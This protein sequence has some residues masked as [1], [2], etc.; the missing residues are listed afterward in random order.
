MAGFWGG[1]G[2]K[3]IFR[4][5]AAHTS[6]ANKTTGVSIG[7]PVIADAAFDLTT[8]SALDHIVESTDITAD[9]DGVTSFKWTHSNNDQA[10]RDFLDI[11]APWK[12]EAGGGT[13]T[14]KTGEE[15]TKVG[16][17]SSSSA[18]QYLVI[19]IGASDGTNVLTTMAIGTFAK[20]SGGLSYKANDLVTTTL[21]FTGTP[22]KADF[23]IPQALFDAAIFDG[24]ISAGLRTI[25]TDWYGKVSNIPIA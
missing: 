17:S 22:S 2:R 21:E 7:A 5:V 16:G 18:V 11:A 6:V 8:D 1:G 20:T 24:A 13:R 4:M 3:L 19:D 12:K 15:G 9:A 25:T 14:E 10:F 23:V